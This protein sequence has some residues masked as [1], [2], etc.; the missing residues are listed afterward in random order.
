MLTSNQGLRK[1]VKLNFR[2]AIFNQIFPLHIFQQIPVKVINL[3]SFQFSS[4]LH[5]CKLKQKKT[6]R[7]NSGKKFDVLCK[8]FLSASRGFYDWFF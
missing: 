5:F 1:K 7:E 6:R 3:S 8:Y 2:F 4:N